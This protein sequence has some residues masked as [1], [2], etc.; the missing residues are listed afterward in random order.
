[1]PSICNTITFTFRAPRNR[2][3]VLAANSYPP[4]SDRLSKNVNN[5]TFYCQLV[6]APEGTQVDFQLLMEGPP[7]PGSPVRVLRLKTLPFYSSSAVTV[8]V[9]TGS[10]TAVKNPQIVS[11]PFFVLF[12]IKYFII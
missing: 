3:S 6:R 10:T 9:G 4:T 8:L 11:A 2:D 12:P 5:T 1:M 7:L